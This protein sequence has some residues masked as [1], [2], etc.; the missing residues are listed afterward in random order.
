MAEQSRT[1]ESHGGTGA[2]PSTADLPATRTW[3]Q[4]PYLWL[5]VLTALVALNFYHALPRYLIPDSS[6]ARI[7]LDPDFHLHYAVVAIHAVTG[8]IA[9]ATVLLQLWPW[10]RRNHPKAHRTSGKFYI[11]AGALPTAMFGV[12]LTFYRP[13]P[14]G[15]IGIA[16]SGVLL[17]L[18]TIVGYR[19][20]RQGRWAEHRRWMSYS[21][22]LAL[23]TTLGR[24]I[25]YVMLYVPAFKPNVVILLELANWASWVAGLLLVHAWLEWRAKRTSVD[26]IQVITYPAPPGA[27][28]PPR[29]L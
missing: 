21:F 10:L 14:N 27:P 22:V 7:V 4:Q 6:Q 26:G 15:S 11:F 8:N 24:L 5:V 12:W 16:T 1:S 18:T 13:M 29:D 28:V 25:F 23:H 20:A 3:W 17:I 9:M 19:M 2:S